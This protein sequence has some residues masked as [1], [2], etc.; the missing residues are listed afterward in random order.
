MSVQVI[1]VHLEGGNTHEHI[2]ELKWWNPADGSTNVS[3][4]SQMVEYV[5]GGGSAYV[6]GAPRAFLHTVHPAG[7][8]PYVQTKADGQWS[9][10]L[11]SLPRY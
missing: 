10:N 1:S 5:D 4:K 11:L 9:N 8:T 7:R 3:S 2:T 6:E